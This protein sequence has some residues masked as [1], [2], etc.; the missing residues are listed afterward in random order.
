M[1][2]NVNALLISKLIM[3]IIIYILYIFVY[4]SKH[5]EFAKAN[6]LTKNR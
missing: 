6:S 2:F 4:Y 3:F 5:Y 1:F